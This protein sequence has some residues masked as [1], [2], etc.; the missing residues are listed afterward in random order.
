MPPFDQ[1]ELLDRVDNDWD[2]LSDTVQMLEADGRELLEEVRRASAEGDAVKLARAAHAI[3]G[4]ISN[5]CAPRAHAS[6]IDVEAI[7]KTGELAAAPAAI[8]LLH[9]R[10]EE[11][12]AG[13][14]ELL[15]SRA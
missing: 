13:L 5:F 10:L 11:L 3:K 12:I 14:T 6:A 2:F 9:A 15:A 4:M 7:G 1:N 8:D